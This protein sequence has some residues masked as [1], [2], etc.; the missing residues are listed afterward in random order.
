MVL[1]GFQKFHSSLLYPHLSIRLFFL[2][3]DHSRLEEA[4]AFELQA[5]LSPPTP[6]YLCPWQ[7]WAA[8][9]PEVT[10][11][12][13]REEVA[14]HRKSCIGEQDLDLSQLKPVGR[15]LFKTGPETPHTKPSLGL[16][17][18]SSCLNQKDPEANNMWLPLSCTKKGSLPWCVVCFR[19]I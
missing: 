10:W 1:F 11:E 14:P 4:K 9:V 5:T 16:T 13:C 3:Q 17:L 7:V 6:S 8:R 19:K 18:H 2:S 12:S 15:A